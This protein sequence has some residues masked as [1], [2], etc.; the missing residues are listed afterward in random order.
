M[1][2]IFLK[3]HKKLFVLDFAII[4]LMIVTVTADDKWSWSSKSRDENNIIDRRQDG[5]KLQRLEDF[6]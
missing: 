2:K 6:R 1:K 3:V 5:G 4:A